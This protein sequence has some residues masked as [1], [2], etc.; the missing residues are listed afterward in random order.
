MDRTNISVAIIPMAEQF[1]WDKTT[2]GFILSSFYFG[3]V[4]TQI[5]GGWLADRYGG[6]AVLGVGVLLWSLFTILSAPAAYFGITALVVARVLMGLGE[7]VTFPSVYSLFARWSPPGERARAVSL[8]LSGVPLGSVVA[9]LVTP[10]L[11]VA[12]GWEAVFYSFGV[13][14]IV[15]WVAWHFLVVSTPEEDP[16]VSPAELATIHAGAPPVDDVRAPI[17]AMLSHPAVW[18][19]IIAFFC[20]N[21]TAYVMIAWLPTY[22]YQALGV[23]LASVGFFAVGPSILGAI[24]YNAAG[25]IAD[26]MLKRGVRLIIVRKIMNSVGFGTAAVVLSSIGFVSSAPLAIG[27]LCVSSFF[28][29]MAMAG[30][31]TSPLD[32]APRYAGTL[33]GISNTIATIPGVVAVTASGMILDATGSWATVFLVAAGFSLIGLISFAVLASGERIFE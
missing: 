31:G 11:I 2:S 21:W 30:C 23:D 5:L 17:R 13:I 22:V 28:G 27:L 14:G 20:S 18:A 26:R 32:I 12:F 29:A 25:W 4:G 10:P 7:G 1:D 3:Y 15:W 16:R 6:K 19:I 24:G 9:L 33:M 8:A